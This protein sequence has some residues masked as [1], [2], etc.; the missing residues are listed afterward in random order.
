MSDP[1]IPPEPP[2][3]F[4]PTENAENQKNIKMIQMNFQQQHPEITA[5]A[6]ADITKMLREEKLLYANLAITYT[7]QAVAA[8]GKR[9]SSVAGK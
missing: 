9:K 8:I 7:V 1:I 2:I 3:V 5:G 4:T 6:N